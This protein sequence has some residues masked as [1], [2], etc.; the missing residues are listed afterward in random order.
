MSRGLDCIAS[1]VPSSAHVRS[2]GGIKGVH[3]FTAAP[4]LVVEWPETVLV[5]KE[6]SSPKE[7]TQW[8]SEFSKHVGGSSN[9]AA[10]S[11]AYG[12]LV[13]QWGPAHPSAKQSAVLEGCV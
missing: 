6:A 12:P 7:A 9:A 10:S 3:G 4:T 1:Q 8:A 13:V 11:A 5:V 2:S